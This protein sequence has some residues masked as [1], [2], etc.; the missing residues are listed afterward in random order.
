MGAQEGIQY[1]LQAAHYIITT[2]GRKDVHFA[3]VGDGTSLAEMK[4]MAGEL[5]ISDFITFTG[6]VPD[7]LLLDVLNTADVCVN[8]DI[9]NDMNDMST[10]NKI[11]E[12]M[13]VGKPIVQ[14]DLT[15]GKFSAQDASLYARPNDPTDMAL[16][17]VELLDDPELRRRMGAFGRKRVIN[18]LEWKYEAPKLLS[19]YERVMALVPGRRT[20]SAEPIVPEPEPRGPIMNDLPSYELPQVVVPATA[21]RRLERT[22]EFLNH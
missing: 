5:G 15:E 3:L 1:L 9:A 17:I 4:R 19:A 11:M 18:E 13:A 20:P 10:M 2:L 12:Y 7:E 21:A 6:R 16:K 8:P 22:D 14:F